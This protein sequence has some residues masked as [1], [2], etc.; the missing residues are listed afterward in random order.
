MGTGFLVQRGGSGGGGGLNFQVAG[1]PQPG[2]AK[3]NTIWIDTDV[4]ITSYIFSATEPEAPADDMVWITI[5]TSSAVEFNALKKNGIQVYPL[6]AKQYVSGAWVDKT[7]K[8]WQGGSWNDWVVYILGNG[9]DPAKIFGTWNSSS[10]S[11]G[12]NNANG[13]ISFYRPQHSGQQAV[14][15]EKIY[16]YTPFSK[17]EIVV[18]SI[19]GSVDNFGLGD[20]SPSNYPAAYVV[21]DKAGTYELEISSCGK[22]YLNC[23]MSYNGCN[24]TVSEIRLYA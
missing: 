17:M 15:S 9:T 14:I 13:T 5:G 24:M 19:T 21:I 8:I 10:G 4:K 2:N 16:D 6:S 18:E 12:L 7:A 11:Y 22:M 1:N 3:E 20:N 23:F